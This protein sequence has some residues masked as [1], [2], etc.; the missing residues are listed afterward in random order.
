MKAVIGGNL[1]VLLSGGAPLSDDEHEF[2]RA[3]VDCHVLQGYGLTETSSTATI[4]DP[5]DPAT[6]HVGAPLPGVFI[7]LEN[8]DEGGYTVKDKQGELIN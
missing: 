6:G 8:W 5:T 1:E 7:R 4:S 3:A 2:L